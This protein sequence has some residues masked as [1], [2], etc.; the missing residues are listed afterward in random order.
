MRVSSPFDEI[1]HCFSFISTE[2]CQRSQYKW[3][4]YAMEYHWHIDKIVHV[5]LHACVCAIDSIVSRQTIYEQRVYRWKKKVTAFGNDAVLYVWIT[6]LVVTTNS[7]SYSASRYCLEIGYVRNYVFKFTIW[8]FK[9]IL[10]KSFNCHWRNI[11]NECIL[12]TSSEFNKSSNK[13]P[14]L[15][16]KSN[17]YI[18]PK[19]KS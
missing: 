1:Q 8:A 13:Y 10:F 3:I 7:K 2:N 5:C 4:Y 17:K 18:F 16:L 11:V 12:C 15:V 14:G 9:E 19:T 6:E